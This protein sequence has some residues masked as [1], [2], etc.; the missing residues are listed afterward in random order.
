MIKKIKILSLFLTL[1]FGIL[2]PLNANAAG[3]SATRII[4]D[5]VFTNKSAMSEADV[6]NFLNSKN[7]VCLKNYQTPE[8]LGNNTYGAN[9]SAARAIWQAGQLY[10]INPQVLLVTLQR[11]QASTTR[12]ECPD[13]RYKT[14]MGYGC[15]ATSPCEEQCFGLS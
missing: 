8:P 13:W 2:Y 4:D 7:S 11:E 9:V 14:V 15:R 12:T 1:S 5:I 3:F 10:N 6:Q